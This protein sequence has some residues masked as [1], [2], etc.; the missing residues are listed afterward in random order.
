MNSSRICLAVCALLIVCGCG[1]SK[2]T[3]TASL[4]GKVTLDGVPAPAGS[5][6]HFT[7]SANGNVAIGVIGDGGD[8]TA[9]FE[10]QEKVF[11][12]DYKVTVSGPAVEV[13][14]EAAM[15]PD[16]VPP[17]DPIPAKYQDA[18]TSGETVTVTEGENTYNLDISS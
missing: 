3:P 12:G 6:I 10:G 18:S 15:E 7:D 9:T 11:P 1:P 14:A 16:F 5:K 13:D 17:T 8:Y 2:P 4:S